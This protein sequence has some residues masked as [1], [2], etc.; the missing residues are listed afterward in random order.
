[1]SNAAKTT[2]IIP[3]YNESK[4]PT[5]PLS[6]ALQAQL[7]QKIVI[8]DDGSTDD[9][10]TQIQQFLDTQGNQLATQNNI[11]VRFIVHQ[12]NQGKT[13]AIATAL[14]EVATDTVLMLDADI[15]D[16][17]PEYIDAMVTSFFDEQADMLIYY[18]T[19]TGHPLLS[20]FDTLLA[21]ELLYCGERMLQT[22]ILKT[23]LAQQTQGYLLE[24]AINLY[25]LDHRKKIVLLK[26]PYFHH[27]MKAEK[28]GGVLSGIKGDLNM[29]R[30]ILKQAGLGTYI[31]QRKHFQS[32]KKS[33]P[34][35]ILPKQKL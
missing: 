6:Y 30:Q 25:C 7:V 18:K 16:F 31:R 9:T 1:M 20:F 24:T 28:E 14:Q 13:A 23:V 33:A 4:R 15:K 34:L 17:L 12:K 8:V 32:L 19:S 29:A 22:E 5:S 3:A 21:S 10:A 2:I 11:E 35:L 27:I 26:G